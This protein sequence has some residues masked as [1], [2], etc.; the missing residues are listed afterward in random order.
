M[1]KSVRD[2][3]ADV[4]I[5]EKEESRAGGVSGVVLVDE[6]D[7]SAG[8]CVGEVCAC[9]FGAFFDRRVERGAC[10]R[11]VCVCVLGVFLVA[12]GV[13]VFERSASTA[14]SSSLLPK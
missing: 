7:S 2:G 6:D 12:V 4:K 11:E 3:V 13:R 9:V 10:V 5:D 1:F 14:A 8:V